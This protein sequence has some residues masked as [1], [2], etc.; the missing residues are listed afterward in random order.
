MSGKE[1]IHS[2]NPLPPP[3]FCGCHY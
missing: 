2:L 1:I 3:F